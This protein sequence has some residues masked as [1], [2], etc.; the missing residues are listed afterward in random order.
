M[1]LLQGATYKIGHQDFFAN[2]SLKLEIL[3][4]HIT[5]SN[6]KAFFGEQ[7]SKESNYSRNF[8][9]VILIKLLKH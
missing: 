7:I 8:P 4:F 5:E 2:S 6:F 1:I 9:R 3:K